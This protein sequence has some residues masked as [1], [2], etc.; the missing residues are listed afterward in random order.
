MLWAGLLSSPGTGTNRTLSAGP[1]AP[2]EP[3]LGVGSISGVEARGPALPKIAE[4]ELQAKPYLPLS[5]F[6]NPNYHHN[7]FLNGIL[8]LVIQ[9]QRGSLNH[10]TIQLPHLPQACTLGLISH[11]QRDESNHL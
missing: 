8:I 3:P 6:R 9:S 10:Y 2:L 11:D 4:A 5:Q 7:F 1:V